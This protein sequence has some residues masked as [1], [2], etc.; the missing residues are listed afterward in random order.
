MLIENAN[1][2][3]Y[4]GSQKLLHATVGVAANR[5]RVVPYPPEVEE[6]Y[7][8]VQAQ[9]VYVYLHDTP[10]GAGWNVTALRIL[11]ASGEVISVTTQ[12]DQ[13]GL[14][15]FEDGLDSAAIDNILE[16]P[17]RVAAVNIVGVG[18]PSQALA[19]VT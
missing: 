11:T 9:T 18:L 13:G 8:D 12:A 7:L 17:V 6:I 4:L 3:P 2:T 19:A 16:G 15:W 14:E 10:E 5:L 1:A